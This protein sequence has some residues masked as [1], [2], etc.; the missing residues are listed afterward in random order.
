VN[1]GISFLGYASLLNKLSHTLAVK[2]LA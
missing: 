1:P 2:G